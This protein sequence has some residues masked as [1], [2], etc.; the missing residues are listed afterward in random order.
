[1]IN[2]CVAFLFVYFSLVPIKAQQKQIIQ[3]LKLTKSVSAVML[4]P[5][6]A[7]MKQQSFFVSLQCKR[8]EK[9]FDIVPVNYI[10]STTLKWLQPNI[11]K[12]KKTLYSVTSIDSLQINVVYLMA[13]DAEVKISFEN[14]LSFYQKNTSS[15]YPCLETITFLGFGPK[16]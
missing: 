13:E 9:D 2:K 4:Y 10:D 8:N 14:I 15:K 16:H 1:M 7:I 11:N 3:D 12:L 6:E 5:D